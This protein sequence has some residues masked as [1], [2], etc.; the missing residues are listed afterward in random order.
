MF[1]AKV[2]FSAAKE[3]A[4]QIAELYAKN[5]VDAVYA[6]YNEFKNVMVQKLL[7]MSRSKTAS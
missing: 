5:E 2:D 7:T 4:E 3:I 1:R 6:I